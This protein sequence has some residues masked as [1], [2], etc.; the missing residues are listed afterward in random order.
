MARYQ[1]LVD[2]LSRRQQR[3]G[4]AAGVVLLHLTLLYILII[5]LRVAT[6]SPAHPLEVAVGGML[7]V[8]TS[9]QHTPV[10]VTPDTPVVPPPVVEIADAI[11]SDATISAGSPDVTMPAQAIAEA[12]SF[13][14]LP[15]GLKSKG[16]MIVRLVISITDDGTIDNATIEGSSGVST[17][18]RLAV[19]WVKMHWRYRPALQYGRTVAALTTAIVVFSTT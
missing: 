11:T 6:S 16:Q 19:D 9:T 7:G 2:K 3:V 4:A 15:E 1:A 5:G 17:L 13:P 18:D 10:L 12:H 14:S 8:E